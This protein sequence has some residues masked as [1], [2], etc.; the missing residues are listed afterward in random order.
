MR[1]KWISQHARYP[2]EA[3]NGTG[4]ICRLHPIDATRSS[5]MFTST[6]TNCSVPMVGWEET[7]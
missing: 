4:F 5:R 2:E 1:K 6:I 3:G 7:V